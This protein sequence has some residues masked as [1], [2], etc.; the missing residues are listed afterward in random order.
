M[1]NVQVGQ[2]VSDVLAGGL[3]THCAVR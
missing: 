1:A 2:V 3:G